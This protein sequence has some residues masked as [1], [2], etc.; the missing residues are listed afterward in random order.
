ML[1]VIIIVKCLPPSNAWGFVK[2]GKFSQTYNLMLKSLQSTG[3]CT[4]ATF[5]F[6]N[7]SVRAK[8]KPIFKWWNQREIARQS[9][10]KKATMLVCVCRQLRSHTLYGALLWHCTAHSFKR[11]D[12]EIALPDMTSLHWQ[13]MIYFATYTWAIIYWQHRWWVVRLVRW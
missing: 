13:K 9:G 11:I 7:N 1:L 3:I 6:R 10:K 5:F 4:K 2:R 12:G 8:I